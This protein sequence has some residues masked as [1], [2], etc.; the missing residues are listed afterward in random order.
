ML[1]DQVSKLCLLY[2][3]GDSLPLT[4]QESPQLSFKNT[5]IFIWLHCVL[6][7]ACGVFGAL[8]GVGWAPEDAGSVAVAPEL[9]KSYFPNQGSNMCPLHYKADS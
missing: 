4:H 5:F 7:A 1:P 6:V 8:Y 3:L 2:W 9:R